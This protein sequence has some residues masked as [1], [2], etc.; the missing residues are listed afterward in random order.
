[1][2]N[3][4]LN[5][6]TVEGFKRIPAHPIIPAVTTS[7]ITFGIREQKSIRKDLNKYNMH[8]AMSKNAY[9]ILSCKPLII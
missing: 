7:G 5:T 3:A 1:M 2:P 9:N 4:T 6:N 8:N